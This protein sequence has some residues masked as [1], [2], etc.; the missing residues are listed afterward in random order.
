MNTGQRGIYIWLMLL[1]IAVGIVVLA[2]AIGATALSAELAVVMLVAYLSM[3]FVALAGNRVRNFQM[4]RPNLRVAARATPAGRRAAQRARSRPEYNGD[5]GVM[6]I[7]LIVNQR[8]GGHWDR[9]LAQSV[10]M[11]EGAVQ[12]YI[13]IDVPSQLAH[14][15]ALIRF[16]MYD[17]AGRLQFTHQIEQWVRDG[18]NNVFCDRQLPLAGNESIGRSGT[19]DLRVTIDGALVAIHSFGVTPST[20][21]RRRQF[22]GDGEAASERL[23]IVDEDVP[24]SLD[25]LLREQR[26]RGER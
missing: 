1:G 6:D 8:R 3:V 23:E 16:E 7:G 25:E 17:Q 13:T 20:E 10:S 18:E 19:W 14:R 2:G 21:A 11:D 4:P 9:R 24:V 22:S 15:L 12:P 26:G 5:S